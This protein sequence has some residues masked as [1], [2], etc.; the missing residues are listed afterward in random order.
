MKPFPDI[1]PSFRIQNT[2][3]SSLNA[4]NTVVGIRVIHIFSWESDCGVRKLRMPVI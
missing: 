2:D 1:G 3:P 4:W